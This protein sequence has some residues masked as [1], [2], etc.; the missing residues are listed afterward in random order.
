MTYNLPYENDRVSSSGCVS[1]NL[2]AGETI[3]HRILDATNKWAILKH[4]NENIPIPAPRVPPN[5]LENVNLFEYRET[6]LHLGNS[7]RVW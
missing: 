1:P 4:E 6:S 7:I 2:I 3:E 5:L